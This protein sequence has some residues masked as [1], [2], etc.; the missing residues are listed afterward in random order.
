M[1]VEQVS[2]TNFRN[3]PSVQLLPAPDGVTLLQGDN[4]SGKTN[5]LEAIA[6]FSTLRSFRGAPKSA[7]VRNGAEQAVLRAMANRGGRNVLVEVEL[8]L[9]GKDKVRLNR[10]P[11]TPP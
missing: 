7:L 1:Y 3:Y 9:D 5:L 8:N 6:Y 11:L 2:L 4:G 10:Q